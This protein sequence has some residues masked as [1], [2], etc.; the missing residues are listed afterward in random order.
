MLLMLLTFWVPRRP[1]SSPQPD[2]LFVLQGYAIV[3]PLVSIQVSASV[4]Y[5]YLPSCLEWVVVPDT[6]PMNCAI[7][8]AARKSHLKSM[9]A[10]GSNTEII[11]NA[12][13][14]E[15]ISFAIRS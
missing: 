11:M 10:I 15:T 13:E 7:T 5:A 12:L 8:L 3:G 9:Q 6:Q 4:K 14:L 1:L 2:W